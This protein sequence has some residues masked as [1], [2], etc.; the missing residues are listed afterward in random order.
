[1]FLGKE[2]KAQKAYGSVHYGGFPFALAGVAA[3]FLV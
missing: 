3:F 1:V 2:H